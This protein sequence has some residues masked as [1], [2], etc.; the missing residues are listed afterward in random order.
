MWVGGSRDVSRRRIVP[1]LAVFSVL[2]LAVT[3][4][5]WGY[6]GAV[7]PN[8]F[9]AKGAGGAG[10]L[11]H[12]GWETLVGRNVNLPAPFVGSLLTALGGL[13]TVSLW[14]FNR[15][16][17]AFLASAVGTG[18]LFSVYAPPDWTGMGRYFGPYVPAAAVLV[19]RGLFAGLARVPR[20]RASSAAGA[21]TLVV[22]LFVGIGAWRGWAHLGARAL[23]EYPGFVLSSETLV[24]A[25]RW[26]GRELPPD[27][28][29]AARRIGALG[30]FGR[31]PV[32]D[33]AFGLTDPGVARAAA[34]AGDGFELPDDP[35]LAGLWLAAR[36]DCLLEDEVV[37]ARLA[38]R[39]R[40][41]LGGARPAP[42]TVHGLR[43]EVIRSFSLGAGATRW[44]LACR[45]GVRVPAGR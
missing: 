28:R 23:G 9:V 30:Y 26:V 44:V 1:A 7:L 42:L 12:R 21:A 35:G 45:P 38:D 40:G 20:L 5:R 15:A 3:L 34:A 43:Y 2:V 17:A 14:R 8:T 4:A 25:A 36:P 11:V 18:L 29:I 39:P 19:V 41:P 16:A 24:P 31:R 27:T 22:L 32:F 37:T 6:F 10:E 13:A 33:Y